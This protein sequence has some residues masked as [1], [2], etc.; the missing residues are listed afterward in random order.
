MAISSSRYDGNNG[1][2]G[3]GSIGGSR[4]DLASFMQTQ[5]QTTA[6]TSTQTSNVQNS[7]STTNNN[8]TTSSNK[9]SSSKTQNMDPSSLA[10]LQGLI[11]Q[12][13][14]GG[15]EQMAQDRA[16]R[17]QELSAVQALRG[18]YSKDAAFADA[19]GA[20]NQYLRQAME[21]AMPTLVRAAEGA[22]TSANS[23]RALLTQDALTRASEGAAALGLQAATNYGTVGAN[24]SSILER[25]T[26]P[27]NTQIQALLNAL[28]VAKGAISNTQSNETGTSS[29]SGTQTTTGTQT[30]NTSQ[31][32]SGTQT[33][34]NLTKAPTGS[35]EQFS[36]PTA[37]G[38]LSGY[39]AGS[40]SLSDL[41][42]A[43]WNALAK[44]SGGGGDWFNSNQ[45]DSYRF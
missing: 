35:L 3:G 21:K 24:Y 8:S 13:L 36:A 20:M 33:L 25:L 12:L 34:T 23:M 7:T 27:D 11:A 5:S 22:G 40:N 1:S 32:T 43:Q 4:N 45:W 17:L 2:I 42:N 15:T 38:G 28:N 41:T 14:G 6:P 16:R 9:Q 44:A 19:Q 39:S 29:T 30:N 37:G 18:A 10:A 26:Q 31:Q